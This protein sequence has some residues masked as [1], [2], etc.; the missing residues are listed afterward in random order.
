MSLIVFFAIGFVSGIAGGMIQKEHGM[1][2]PAGY[3][4][5]TILSVIGAALFIFLTGCGTYRY[6]G[7][8][9]DVCFDGRSN[10]EERYSCGC[11]RVVNNR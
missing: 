1:G 8:C 7:N 4:I 6:H 11:A 5:S 9:G 10:T 2:I 3:A